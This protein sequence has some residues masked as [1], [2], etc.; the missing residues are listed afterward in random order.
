MTRAR[1]AEGHLHS[2]W[3]FRTVLGTLGLAASALATGTTGKISGKVVDRQTMA[4]LPGANIIVVGT[5]MGAT[6]DPEGEYFIANIPPGVYSVKA[7]YIGY[8]DVMVTD[9]RVHIDQTTEL[10]FELE[11][12]VLE[13]STPIVVTAQRPLIQKDNTSSRLIVASEE[14]R[15]RPTTEVTQILTSLPGIEVENGQMTVRGGTIDQVAFMIDG[16][17]ARNPLDQSPYMNVNLSS[18]QEMEVITGSFN[19]EYGE[20]QSGVINIVTKEG[21]EKYHV[22]LDSRITPPG[23]RHWGPALYD[24]GSDFYWENSNARHLQWWID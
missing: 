18:I 12:K 21:G 3:L 1:R 14:L 7:S 10:K 17:R 19:A 8:R 13:L 4:S 2:R 23:K 20:A 11:E 6:T 16:A 5:T 15:V 9:V 22:F 24:Y